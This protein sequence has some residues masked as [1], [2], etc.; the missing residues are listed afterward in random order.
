V[1]PAQERLK[2]GARH[3][4]LIFGSGC[5]RERTFY[6]FRHDIEAG[7]R[8]ERYQPDHSPDKEKEELTAR[9]PSIT[10][11]YSLSVQVYLLPVP[12]EASA[13]PVRPT[14]GSS[15]EVR[16]RRIGTGPPPAVNL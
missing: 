10:N 5:V 7:L 11:R 15:F 13:E 16:G 1:F 9:R 8:S 14:A 3:K 12:L 4:S 2:E 6:Y